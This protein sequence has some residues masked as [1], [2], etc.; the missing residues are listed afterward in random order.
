[1]WEIKNEMG[2]MKYVTCEIK[3]RREKKDVICR[4]E[5]WN[6]RNKIQNMRNEIQHAQNEIWEG[7]C[8]KWNST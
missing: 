6:V 4:N 5:I 3:M 7:T 8:A 1:M 2:E